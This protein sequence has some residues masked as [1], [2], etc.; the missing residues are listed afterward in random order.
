MLSLLALLKVEVLGR[1]TRP[2]PFSA[3]S[4]AAG[5]ASTC[6]LRLA[7]DMRL[8]PRPLATLTVLGLVL[9][10]EVRPLRKEAE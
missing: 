2:L 8:A 1:L 9:N 6:W 3:S 5:S 4:T 7:A 10:C